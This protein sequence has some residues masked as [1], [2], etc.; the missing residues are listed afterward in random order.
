MTSETV[1]IT[2]AMPVY[3]GEEFLRS[4]IE[5]VLNQSY[6]RFQLLIVDDGSGD[7]SVSIAYEM[8]AR[9]KRVKVF[10]NDKNLGLVGNWNR[11]LA[12]AD[13]EWFKFHFQDDLLHSRAL[14]HLMNSAKKQDVPVILHNREYFFEGSGTEMKQSYFRELPGLNKICKA[15]SELSL[16]LIAETLCEETYL[17]NF[18][19]EPISAIFKKDL[20]EKYGFY[21]SR[22]KQ[23]CDFEFWL[24][25]LVNEPAF[26]LH[27][28]LVSF[29]VHEQSESSRN[30]AKKDVVLG[31]NLILWSFLL[32][33]PVFERLRT[34]CDNRELNLRG[35]AIRFF[36]LSYK[37]AGLD[38]M[39][40]SVRGRASL[41][42]L[43]P[44]RLLLE[45]LRI[46]K[47]LRL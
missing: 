32:K 15:D 46:R 24:R 3:N 41:K 39:K 4:S 38:R 22:L 30:Q 17:R 35:Q 44:S 9:D 47:A 34:Y 2:V 21:D 14:E 7:S 40:N 13:T 16:K 33:D 19:G 20:V 43:V 25:L 27:K 26:Y 28:P 10:K 37:N 23:K 31:D 5:S 12:L 45:K 8:A 29:R 42:K 6:S 1:R 36:E 11:C 18:I